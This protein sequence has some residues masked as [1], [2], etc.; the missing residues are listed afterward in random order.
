MPWQIGLHQSWIDQFVEDF[1][2]MLQSTVSSPE[3]QEYFLRVVARHWRLKQAL[4]GGHWSFALDVEEAAVRVET[5]IWDEMVWLK[6]S[7]AFFAV[8]RSDFS[9]A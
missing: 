7:H 9:A 4:M 5:L 8:L 2:P 1:R 3:A 6:M